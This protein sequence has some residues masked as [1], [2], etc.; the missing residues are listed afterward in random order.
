MTDVETRAHR[1]AL[2]HIERAILSGEF[3]VGSRLP[4][5]RELAAQLGVSRGA[6]R[7][8]IRK[9]QAQGILESFPGPGRGTRITAGQSQA[10]G[11]MFRLHLAIAA[12]SVED[13]YTARIALEGATAA[14]AAKHWTPAALVELERIL[15]EM[16]ETTDLPTFNAMD[17]QFHVEV[18]RTARNPL[19]GDLTSAIREALRG[20]ILEQ[21]KAME[22]WQEFRL[23]LITEHRGVF[24][25]IADRD[26]ELAQERMERHIRGAAER[27]DLP[28][29]PRRR[30]E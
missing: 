6:V 14:L 19:I 22:D 2:D 27:L 11:Q 21:S 10:L 3:P 4:P 1:V 7:E 16:D 12:N 29:H 28:A 13:L 30:S 20:P 26:P 17:T 24:E 25:A 8:A 15:D 23:R 5:E 18:A 9:L